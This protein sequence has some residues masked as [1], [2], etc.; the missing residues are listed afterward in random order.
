MPLSI[1]QSTI[2]IVDDTPLNLTILNK[3]LSENYI[4]K[5][6]IN[7]EKA[8][9]ISASSDSIDL[10]LLDIHMPG[11]NGFEV[12]KRLKANPQT[13]DIP[14]IFL[15]GETSKESE[16]YGFEVGAVDFINKPINPA[17]VKARIKTH[18]TL[19]KARKKLEIQN[20]DLLAEKDLVEDIIHRMRKWDQ[21]DDKN[22]NYLVSSAEKSNGD[23]L[24]SACRTDG[25]QLVLI[26]DFTGH[27]LPA[28]VGNP[29]VAYIFYTMVSGNFSFQ[30]I[31]KELNR[32]VYKM[33]PTSIYMAACFL[34][35]D[36]NKEKIKVW[37]AGL[38]D[39]LV[40][41]NQSV[42]KHITSESL[43]LGV[44]EQVDISSVQEIDFSDAIK[45]YAFSDG[46]IEATAPDEEMF[47]MK[48]LEDYLTQP[49]DK[50]AKI[51][52]LISE[53]EKF[54]QSNQQA[55]DITII[56]FYKK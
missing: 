53:I 24:L 27:G 38:P 35:T 56:E 6:A 7:G 8:L 50:G 33:L 45:V 25:S 9:A 36:P 32:A 21:F 1:E 44:I 15:T 48:R 20:N 2:L 11:I 49:S 5:A 52:N 46:I 23:L 16:S 37:N 12:C 43:P 51:D 22:L 19:Q 18:L 13:K 41:E 30:E 10:I 40:T 31:I 29:I 42:I 39:I 28:A 26:G 14:V 3:V 34:E 55:D 54:T 17:I 4:V 47:G